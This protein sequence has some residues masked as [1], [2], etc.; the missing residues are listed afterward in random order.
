ML[1]G[2]FNTIFY[3]NATGNQPSS[4]RRWRICTEKITPNVYQTLLSGCVYG[5]Y[6]SAS[7]GS[8]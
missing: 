8:C 6:Q 3:L 1:N 4:P 2:N 5:L 7:S